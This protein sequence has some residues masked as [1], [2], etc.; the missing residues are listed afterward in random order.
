LGRRRPMDRANIATFNVQ[1]FSPEQEQDRPTWSELD[2]RVLADLPAM[3][4]AVEEDLENLLP[5]N[6]KVRIT[7]WNR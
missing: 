4:E 5:E 2:K 7:E 1:I 6:Y 3:L